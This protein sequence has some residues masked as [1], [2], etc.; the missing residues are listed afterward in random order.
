MVFLLANVPGQV[1][2]LAFGA[3]SCASRNR[4]KSAEGMGIN[5]TCP[6]ALFF[7]IGRELLGWICQTNHLSSHTK[8]TKSDYRS[9]SQ[10]PYL[11]T[12]SCKKDDEDSQAESQNDCF[13][14]P[15]SLRESN[16]LPPYGK[17]AKESS[18]RRNQE[19]QK[20]NPPFSFCHYVSD[21]FLKISDH[22]NRK[23]YQIRGVRLVESAKMT[24]QAYFLPHTGLIDVSAYPNPRNEK[25]K[26]AL[27]NGWLRRV[28]LSHPESESANLDGQTEERREHQSGC[29][30]ESYSSAN[31][32]DEV[33]PLASGAAPAREA[34]SA[35]GGTEVPKG[36]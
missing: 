5:C 4:D 9:Q 28:P 27:V 2:P 19:N 16:N 24:Y 15:D 22:L 34:G 14:C 7:S 12:T 25:T 30:T 6:L 36:W 18:V 29:G 20:S 1:S 13:P 3:T 11:H 10:Q 21:L 23:L 31:V 32:R 17:V 26:I 35:G 33:S 8:E